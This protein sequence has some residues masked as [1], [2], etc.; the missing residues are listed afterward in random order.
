MA[1]KRTKITVV[2]AG[3]IGSAILYTLMLK[4]LAGELVL[5]NRN[6]ERA[7][8]KAADIYHCTGLDGG[9]FVQSGDIRDS[10]GSEIV[11]ITAGVLPEE[12]GSRTDVLEKNLAIYKKMVP[13]IM[14]YSPG[15]ILLVLTNPVDVMSYAAM[16]LSAV[17]PSRVIG[18][19]TLLDTIRLRRILAD[20]SGTEPHLLDAMVIGEHG[21]SLIPLWGRSIG[22]D[23]EARR[24]IEESTKRA[25]WEIRLAKEHSC[26]AISLAA[27]RI[28]EAILGRSEGPLPV[29]VYLSGQY[30]I[31]DMYLSLP[32][33]LGSRGVTKI[34]EPSLTV[35]EA[36]KLKE[37]AEELGV[38][39]AQAD[40]YLFDYGKET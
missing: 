5:L 8:A 29:S 37:S 31:K 13:E 38:F 17:D 16:K 12:N 23:E 30:G 14:S 34:L 32:V 26:Y 9:P 39:F 28:V 15:C 36:S 20:R 11:I 2:G 4:N 22:L 6:R 40:K 19:G 3:E 33:L 27:V 1:Y 24:E 35:A 25:G 18:T 7:E 21:D 10:A